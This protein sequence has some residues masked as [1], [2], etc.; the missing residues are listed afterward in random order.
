M[1]NW[2]CK[3]AA[4]NFGYAFCILCVSLPAIASCNTVYRCPLPASTPSHPP[5]RQ[6]ETEV[7]LGFLQTRRFVDGCNNQLSLNIQP[8]RCLWGQLV[9]RFTHTFIIVFNFKTSRSYLINR[10]FLHYTILI[11][12]N[13]L[14][15]KDVSQQQRHD[16]FLWTNTEEEKNTTIE[17]WE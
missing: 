3:F 2:R 8:C 17:L 7:S 10:H 9:I 11:I 6:V 13:H 15:V 1:A 4:L 12:G 5:H 16:L 14:T